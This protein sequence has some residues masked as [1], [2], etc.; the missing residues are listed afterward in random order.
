MVYIINSQDCYE[1]FG[2]IS[3]VR[4]QLFTA[5]TRSKAW[6]RVL[7][8]G[9]NMERLKKEFES[10]KANQFKL[11]FQYP[12]E[13]VRKKLNIVNRDMTEDEK[14]KIRKFES[15][16]EDLL[17]NIDEGNVQLEDLDSDQIKKFKKLIENEE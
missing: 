17:K 13:A 7:G 14:K 15:L 4:N 2:S 5:I 11:K 8:V 12:T 1:S 10:V 16:L 6:V 3:A 9:Q